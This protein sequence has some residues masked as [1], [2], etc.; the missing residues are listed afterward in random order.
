MPSRTIFVADLAPAYSRTALMD[1]AL[2]TV[3]SMRPSPL[4]PSLHYKSPPHGICAQ[5]SSI[6][7][8]AS[9]NSPPC[10]PDVRLAHRRRP[11]KFRCR[12]CCAGCASVLCGV[13]LAP[14]GVRC[15]G[16]SAKALRATRLY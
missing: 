14:C 10:A 2:G 16:A 12:R 13:I 1:R 5:F 8:P 15:P 11:F 4:R 6:I 3:S 9:C 7:L